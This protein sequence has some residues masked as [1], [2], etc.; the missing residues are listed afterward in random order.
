MHHSVQQFLKKYANFRGK[1][2]SMNKE[3][4]LLKVSVF[5]KSFQTAA[6]RAS[7][8]DVIKHVFCQRKKTSFD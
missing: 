6:V 3:I 7:A 1:F 8:V 2:F 4:N 5:K